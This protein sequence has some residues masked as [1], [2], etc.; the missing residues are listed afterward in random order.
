MLVAVGNLWLNGLGSPLEGRANFA[1]TALRRGHLRVTFRGP[2]V[3]WMPHL[4]RCRPSWSRLRRHYRRSEDLTR[5]RSTPQSN[6]R[7][8][9][10]LGKVMTSGGQ[11]N[12]NDG[13]CTGGR[14]RGG[15]GYT[16][17][18]PRV[19]IRPPGCSHWSSQR[20]VLAPRCA[21]IDGRCKAH[22]HLTRC[23]G[24]SCIRPIIIGHG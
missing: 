18:I 1:R 23:G 9:H 8:N 11:S 21:C 20:L 3:C 10:R 24:A 22:I 15:N 7:S 19:C 13:H 5:N 14:N 12:G 2:L 17:H 16:S 6:A 4:C